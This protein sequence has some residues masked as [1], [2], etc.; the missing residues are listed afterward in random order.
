MNEQWRQQLRDKMEGY[1]RPAPEVSWEKIDQALDARKP[2]RLWLWRIAAAVAVVLMITGVGYWVSQQ[3]ETKQPPL[4]AKTENVKQPVETAN[5]VEAITPVEKMTPVPTT[6]INPIGLISHVGRKSQTDLIEPK[7]EQ[8]SKTEQPSDTID[9]TKVETKTS[10]TKN[11]GPSTETTLS[12]HTMAKEM[13]SPPDWAMGGMARRSYNRLT[14]KVYISN[15]MASS[16]FIAEYYSSNTGSMPIDSN[17]QTVLPSNPNNVLPF[18]NEPDSGSMAPRR[19]PK[20]FRD[21]H[22]IRYHQ[23]IRIGFSLRY[24]LNNNW[25]IES[26]LLYTI[27]VTDV[28]GTERRFDPEETAP[29][30]GGISGTHIT[31]LNEHEYH[32]YIGLPLNVSYQVW[33]K[34][35]FD[36]Y[37]LA[38][39][40][41]EKMLDAN[42][43]Q[44]S[45]NI[46]A[47]AEYRLTDHLSFYA[48]PGMGYYFQNKSSIPTIYQEDPFNFNISL[49]LRINLK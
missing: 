43:W 5:P 9:A 19:I 6:S 14:A 11:T 16:H 38:G 26:G 8:S 20:V 1:Q 48:E 30:V 18:N 34:R 22:D 23:P 41:I 44:F 13:T 21:Y 40:T 29:V 37:V 31:A 7:N 45:L 49:G 42:P 10:L 4:T 33:K 39:G 28:K 12:T 47:G 32:S 2:R 3:G 27:L 35:H 15:V 24:Q 25:S 46:A 36:F 17:Y